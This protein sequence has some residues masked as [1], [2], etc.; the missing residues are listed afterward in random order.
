MKLFFYVLGLLATS[1]AF[2]DNH[3]GSYA[4]M[5]LAQGNAVQMQM[6]SLQPRKTMADRDRVMNAYLKWAQDNEVEVF[7]LRLTPLYGGPDPSG[8]VQFEWIELLASPYATT[9]TAWDKWLTTDEGR[10]INAQWLE[11]SECRV[12]V[13]PVFNMFLD[14]EALSGNTRVMTF[15]WCTRQEGV[16]WDQLL[17][18]HDTMLAGRPDDSPVGSWTIMYP[19]LGVRNP[20]GEFAHLVSYPDVSSLMAYQNTLVNEEGWRQRED[21]YTSYADCIGENVYRGEVLNRP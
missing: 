9:G 19:G 18:R 17:A 5:D 6:C 13:N 8:N 11:T 15:N 10:R 12:S 3:G 16:S 20:I 1:M 4:G 14:R 2:A 7:V 21:Y